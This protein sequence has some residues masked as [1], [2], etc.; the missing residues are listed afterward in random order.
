MLYL[1]RNSH[2][3]DK[4]T[5]Y[6]ERHS[7]TNFLESC[8][9]QQFG[10]DLTYFFGFK[11]WFGFTKPEIISYHPIA[12]STLFIGIVRNPYDWL[13]AFYNAPHHVPRFNSINIK[14]FLNNEWYSIDNNEQE[15]KY[16]RNFTTKPNKR[17]I[18]IFELRKIKCEYLSQMM[19]LFAKNYVLI[20]YDSFLKNHYN[21]LN[22][23][24]SR[25]HLKKIGTPPT[26]YAKTSYNFD[27]DIKNLIDSS[28]DWTVEESLGYCQ[29]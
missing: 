8:I 14:T 7:G 26:P 6:G 21:Y 5:I 2:Y 16:D 1:C 17:Y 29:K 20:S 10:L 12:R 28:L 15:I 25:F 19:P 9:K 18:N 22:I 11:H 13:G 23:I 27:L 4:F 24:G 3:I